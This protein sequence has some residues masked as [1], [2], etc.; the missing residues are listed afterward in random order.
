MT[1]SD[2]FKSQVIRPSSAGVIPSWWPREATRVARPKSGGSTKNERVGGTGALIFVDCDGAETGRVTWER[3]QPQE[4]GEQTIQ[5][6]CSDSGS[7][8][9]S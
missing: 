6:G 7:G 4:N 3:G 1:P 8:S 9:G 2:P 5:A